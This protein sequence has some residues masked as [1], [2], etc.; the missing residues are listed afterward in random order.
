MNL[1]ELPPTLLR[2]AQL[3]CYGMWCEATFLG[4]WLG[5]TSKNLGIS[6]PTPNTPPELH[7]YLLIVMKLAMS[8]S[9][10]DDSDRSACDEGNLNVDAIL[11][12]RE[13]EDRELLNDAVEDALERRHADEVPEMLVPAP[14][15]EILELWKK[16]T[17]LDPDGNEIHKKTIV[18]LMN[19]KISLTNSTDRTKRLEFIKKN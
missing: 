3:C 4:A 16:K 14:S 6:F 18:E 7:L 11:N 1:L 9:T 2:G 17:V 5:E 10:G 15:P 8:K 12:R 13:E 19:K